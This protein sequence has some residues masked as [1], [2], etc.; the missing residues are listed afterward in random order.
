M[1]TRKRI[2][3]QRNDSRYTQLWKVLVGW[4]RMCPPRGKQKTYCIK[5]CGAKCKASNL[6]M[7][8]VTSVLH[9]GWILILAKA[10]WQTG[11]DSATYCVRLNKRCPIKWLEDLTWAA[12]A[13]KTLLFAA[14]H[15]CGCGC[16]R[17]C[18]QLGRL[19][20]AWHLF[21]GLHPAVRR[22]LELQRWPK[23]KCWR[24]WAMSVCWPQRFTKL[25]LSSLL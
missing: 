25:V 8:D 24:G 9:P 13:V 20:A 12:L 7:L 18:R 14:W 5:V 6:K 22:H 16:D 4:L 19:S 2:K 15:L 23:D 1:S 21:N 11:R 17:S 3:C 10:N